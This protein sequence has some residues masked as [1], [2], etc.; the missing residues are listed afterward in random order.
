MIK[1]TFKKVQE[2]WQDGLFSEALH[3]FCIA[4][5]ECDILTELKLLHFSKQQDDNCF[6]FTDNIQSIEHVK[7][8]EL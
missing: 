7:P 5:T 4:I 6:V 8:S 1:V 3:C 2:I